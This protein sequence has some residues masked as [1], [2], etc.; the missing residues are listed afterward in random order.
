MCISLFILVLIHNMMDVVLLCSCSNVSCISVCFLHY[1]VNKIFKIINMIIT[2]ELD[3]SQG[4]TTCLF[5]KLCSLL[6]TNTGNNG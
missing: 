2:H 4:A 6:I 1:T 5:T 3:I